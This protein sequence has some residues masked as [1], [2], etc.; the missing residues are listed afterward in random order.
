MAVR[1]WNVLVGSTGEVKEP[2]DSDHC[3]AEQEQV[4]GVE[5]VLDREVIEWNGPAT[6]ERCDRGQWSRYLYVDHTASLLRPAS[7]VKFGQPLGMLCALPVSTFV[8]MYG[9]SHF[10]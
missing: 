9:L 8:S 6:W 10:T 4:T 1:L 3:E 2:D 7:R 5:A